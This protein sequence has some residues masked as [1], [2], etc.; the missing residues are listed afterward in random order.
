[1]SAVLL[2]F[3][4]G[5]GRRHGKKNRLLCCHCVQ[6]H[7]GSGVCGHFLI[8]SSQRLSENRLPCAATAPASS[9]I[10]AVVRLQ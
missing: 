2:R 9:S 4:A 10:H 6:S 8:T 7:D 1:M 5:K 3:S